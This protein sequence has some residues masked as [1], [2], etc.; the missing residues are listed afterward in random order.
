MNIKIC[1][2]Y[3]YRISVNG[4]YPEQHES[5]PYLNVPFKNYFNISMTPYQI[6]TKQF[7]SPSR[8][9]PKIVHVFLFS[10]IQY[11]VRIDLI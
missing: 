7:F 8:F 10:P 6:S 1:R 2:L 9:H 11:S 3:R 5:N 4:V